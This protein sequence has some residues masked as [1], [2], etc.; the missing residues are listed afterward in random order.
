M[1]ETT[2]EKFGILIKNDDISLLNTTINNDVEISYRKFKIPKATGGYRLIEVPNKDLMKKQ[3][4]ILNELKKI[5]GTST[6]FAHAYVKNRNI[7]THSKVHAGKYYFVKIDLSNF[8]WTCRKD[9]FI[10]MR[11]YTKYL[12]NIP[13]IL[14]DDIIN[15]CFY[16]NRLAMGAPTSPMLSNIIMIPI[17]YRIDKLAKSSG[18]HGTRDNISYSRYADDIMISSDM[19]LIKVL[20]KLKCFFYKTPFYINK[21]KTYSSNWKR[22]IVITG[23][24]SNKK[25][26]IKKVFYKR[27]R[28]EIFNLKKDLLSGR[29]NR[30]E[31]SQINRLIGIVN[32]FSFVN[33]RF[34]YMK[35]SIKE[36]KSIERI[37]KRQC[38]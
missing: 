31:K 8:F 30:L 9:W 16:K 15:Y 25:P 19:R 17:D 1:D 4:Q 13:D 23:L 36:L 32:Y 38:N 12:D 2:L 7:I 37:K 24:V 22:R 3:R 21:N 6:K 34:E 27:I 20:N 33:K 10:F 5:N 29:I 18:R 11:N 28:A 26:N 14:Y 35:F